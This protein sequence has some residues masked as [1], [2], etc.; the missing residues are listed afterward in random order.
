MLIQYILFF[1]L[2]W[3]ITQSKAIKYSKAILI[4]SLTVLAWGIG[5]RDINWADSGIYMISFRDYTHDIFNYDISEKP[6]GYSEK[7]FYFLGVFIK[8]F[9]NDYHIYFLL[10]GALSMF[11]LYKGLQRYSILPLIGLCTYIARFFMGRNLVQIR[12]GLAYVIIIWGIKYIQEK[13]FWKYLL[14]VFIASLFHTSAWIALPLYFLSNWIDVN[15]KIIIIGLVIAFILGGFF[16]GPISALV[17][18]NASDLSITTYTQGIFVDRALGLG[19][20]MIYF[21]TFLLLAYTFLEDRIKPVTPYYKIIRDGYFYST[22]ILII[23]CS[24]TALSGR[25][26]TIFATLEFAIIPSLIFMFNKKNRIFALFLMGIAL[27]AIFYL[28]IP[29][30]FR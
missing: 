11:F 13:Q 5:W 10:V 29:N 3:L 16:Q 18:E 9:T 28:N 6:W 17:A 24:F 12:A 21:Q 8:T 22:L 14:L 2:C 27:S 15:K 26:S 7:G 19:N 23:F 25:T 4:I 20:P 1:F 30:Q